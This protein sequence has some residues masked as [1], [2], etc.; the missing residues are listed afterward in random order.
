MSCFRGLVSPVRP[1]NVCL[2]L[3]TIHQVLFLAL[4]AV[5]K[6]YFRSRH[7]LAHSF[8]F[9]L[10]SGCQTGQ[11]EE[12]KA[13]CLRSDETR[14]FTSWRF[15]RLEVNFPKEFPEKFQ[16]TFPSVNVNAISESQ[17]C[18]L[19]IT[20]STFTAEGTEHTISL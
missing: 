2:H 10:L 16:S 20:G 12:G 3:Q 9:V 4:T 17:P 15:T 1:L 8:V 19:V 6:W 5:S 7:I 18:L 14:V 11:R 13:A